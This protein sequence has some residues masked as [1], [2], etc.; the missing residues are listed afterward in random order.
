MPG[1][2]TVVSFLPDNDVGFVV[3][4]NGYNVGVP[5]TNIANIIDTALHLRSGPEPPIM[6]EKKAIRFP[7]EDI[8]NLELPLEEFS[9][10]YTDPGYGTFTFCSP[11]SSSSHCQQVITN[12][13]AVD[14]VQSSAPS[15]PQLLAAWPRVWTSHIR[16]VHQ[17]GNKFVLL[18]TALFPEGYGRDSTPFETAEIGTSEAT[19]EFVVE[20][21]KVVG[22]GL[23]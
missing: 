9:G 6:P 13:T 1:F 14:S 15:S 11:S 23:F 17:S 16:A 21:G 18:W 2:T 19:A 8:V 5:M 4:A 7:Q 12:F 10:T 3:F 20:D 22:F